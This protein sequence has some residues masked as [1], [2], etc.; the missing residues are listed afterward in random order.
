MTMTHGIPLR[1]LET[2]ADAEPDR[3]VLVTPEGEVSYRALAD[4]VHGRAAVLRTS[5]SSGEVIPIPV[6]LD[7]SSVVEIL[8]TS[9]IGGVPLPYGSDFPRIEPGIHADA[10]VCVS[11]SGSSGSQKIVR[12]TSENIEASVLA[13]RIRLRNEAKDRWLLCLPLNHVGGLSVMWR[14]LE[15]GGSIALA[16]FD[17]GLPHFLSV[18]KPTI[19]SLVPTMVYRLLR[20]DPDV[21]ASLRFILVGGARVPRALLEQANAAGVSLV[22]SYGSTEST[23]QIATSELGGDAIAAHVGPPLDGVDVTIV[24]DHRMPVMPGVTGHITVSGHIVSPGYLGEPDRVGP[25]VTGDLGSL[26]HSGRLTVL[27][28]IDDRI[29]SGGENVFL[30]TVS[31]TVRSIEGVDDAVAVGLPDDEWGT[32]VAV[33]VATSRPVAMLDSR[34]REVLSPHEVPKHWAIVDAI[35]T[36]P[37]GKHDLVAIRQIASLR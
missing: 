35:P 23:S 34:V 9:A 26:D 1:W 3:T 5:E 19:A 6:H 29:V 31:E 25:L 8:A 12:L 27:G 4:L 13:S 14:S 21:L 16:P 18:V 15:A 30:S 22:R 11:T 32:S 7:L 17:I 20:A 10:A 28:R 24:D 2:W 33:V 37:N 36:L